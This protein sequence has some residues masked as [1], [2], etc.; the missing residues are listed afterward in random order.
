MI[1]LWV[2][3]LLLYLAWAIGQLESVLALEIQSQAIQVK[4]YSE[5]LKTELLLGVCED[6][7]RSIL[8]NQ[9]DTPENELN[10]LNALGCRVRMVESRAV[11]IPKNLPIN[12]ERLIE[13]EVGHSLRL[14]SLL[15]HQII[16]QETSRINWQVIYESR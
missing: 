9:V 12:N 8:L 11:A 5:F 6:Q 15:E 3:S 7:V 14:R 10:S 13:L 16:S 4:H 2:M 1:L